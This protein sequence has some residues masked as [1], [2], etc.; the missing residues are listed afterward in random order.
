MKIIQVFRANSNVN[1]KV[2]F[3]SLV[4]AFCEARKNYKEVSLYTDE[5]GM[6]LVKRSQVL[7][8]TSITLMTEGVVQGQSTPC[9]FLSEGIYITK[10]VPY[11]TIVNYIDNPFR[12]P[13]LK[14]SAELF[15]LHRRADVIVIP[16]QLF[17]HLEFFQFVTEYLKY[18]HHE[19]YSAIYHL[20]AFQKPNIAR[21][22]D[23]LPI[24]EALMPSGNKEIINDAYQYE[25]ARYKIIAS[26]EMPGLDTAA[27]SF[28]TFRSNA[29]VQLS[30]SQSAVVVNSKWNWTIGIHLQELYQ[31][32]A[33]Y[34]LSVPPAEHK[35]ILVLDKLTWTFRSF[36]TDALNEL[37]VSVFS[38]G[39][40]L[41]TAID[42]ILTNFDEGD[43]DANKKDISNMVWMRIYELVVHKA[44]VIHQPEIIAR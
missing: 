41:T 14:S 7:E 29:D 10:A 18:H 12:I 36:P 32:K 6:E 11:E 2:R 25:L 40:L 24:T 16:P 43:L 19:V 42:E 20:I 37:I 22:Q 13:N 39:Q 38:D 28:D 35:Y 15:R 1:L 17:G 31:L 4:L 44:L 21:T 5:K 27:P 30:F 9:I 3:A 26:A 34:N 8:Y 23:F 33:I